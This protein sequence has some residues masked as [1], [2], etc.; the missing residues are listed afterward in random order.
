MFVALTSQD[1]SLDS[2]TIGD[3]LIRVDGAVGLLS[4]EELLKELDD[5]GNTGGTSD[6]HNLVDLVLAHSRVPKDLFD[7]RNSV[8][9]HLQAQLLEL[10]SGN[11][12]RVV[13][14]LGQ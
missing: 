8:L 1:C 7:W 12:N 3:G 11:G 4:V 13:L 10:G 2:S 9:E 14:A 6:Q 5:F